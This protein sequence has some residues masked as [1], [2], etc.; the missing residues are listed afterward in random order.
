[1]KTR[2]WRAQ[3]AD[4]QAPATVLESG[5]VTGNAGA[6]LGQ[7]G[8]LRAPVLW[9]KLRSWHPFPPQK[10]GHRAEF[11]GVKLLPNLWPVCFLSEV[12][13]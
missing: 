4:N 7:S 5:D 1:M 3:R 6:G 9:P 13:I 12:G 10:P 8:H 11:S 2:L